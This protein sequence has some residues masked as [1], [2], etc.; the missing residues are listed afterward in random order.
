MNRIKEYLIK[1]VYNAIVIILYYSIIGINMGGYE[2]ILASL[3]M[4]II[5]TYLYDK[6]IKKFLSSLLSISI[7]YIIYLIYIYLHNPYSIN[8]ILTGFNVL[9]LF[10][11]LISVLVSFSAILYSDVLM[12]IYGILSE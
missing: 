8:A 5:F 7:F 1:A 6:L 2:V 4:G 12:R 9:I 10:P 11:Y 3:L